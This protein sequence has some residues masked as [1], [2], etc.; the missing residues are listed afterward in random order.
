MEDHM[1]PIFL[2]NCGHPVLVPYIPDDRNKIVEPILFQFLLQVVEG[3]FRLIDDDHGFV[4]VMGDLPY[5]FAPYGPGTTGNYNYLILQFL[6]YPSIFNIDGHPIQE[7]LDLDLFDLGHPKLPIDPIL[8]GRYD[9]YLYRK[10]DQFR[11]EFPQL[12]AIYVLDRKNNLGN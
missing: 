10:I 9:L 3:G 12:V 1:G 8:Y 6:G 5:Q 2:K 7:I 11:Y 4:F